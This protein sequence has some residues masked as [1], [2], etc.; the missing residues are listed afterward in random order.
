MPLKHLLGR[1]LKNAIYCQLK[2]YFFTAFMKPLEVIVNKF[3]CL[4]V[5]FSLLVSMQ[6]RAFGNIVYLDTRYY[7]NDLN[8][9]QALLKIVEKLFIVVVVE[10][11]GVY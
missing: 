1:I 9:V 10:L 2:R 7:L 4:C 3:F 6:L 8:A 5:C 11:Q